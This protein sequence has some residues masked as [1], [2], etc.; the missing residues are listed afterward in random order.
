MRLNPITRKKL[1][2]FR[3][4]RRGFWSFIVLTA[5]V[6][7]A[8]FAELLINNRALIVRYEGNTYFPTY[9]AI[10]P[11][12]TFG[13]DYDWETD[14][15]QLRERFL[16]Q[17]AGGGEKTGNWVLM[18]PVPYNPLENCNP[19]EHIRPRAPDFAQAHYL[20]T[21]TQ[22]RDILARLVYGFRNAIIFAFFF[23]AGIYLLGILLGCAMGYFGGTFDLLVQRLIE[24]WSNIPFLYVVIIVASIV[25]PSLGW[26]VVITV[27]FSWMGMTYYMRT[28][29]YKEK[30]R[31]YVAAAQVL[32]AGDTR[33]IFRHIL[34]NT[35]AT[36]VTFVPFTVAGAITSITALDFLGFGLPVPTPSWGEL[37]QQGTRHLTLAPWIVVSTFTAMTLVL[38][39]VTFVGEAVREAFD[40]K[41]FTI[42]E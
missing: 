41:K 1:R 21:D 36:L 39:L 38:T 34:P 8:C 25:R 33:I 13:L 40:P 7:L 9:G 27:A 17:R 18:P 22:N 19:G 5:L 24:I 16:Q 15:R 3:S 23:M 28:G 37:L 14:Y 30:A 2:R 10:I 20:G 4:L 29:T 12:K 6:V 42:Y 31:D 26:L 11:G 32:G 35:A